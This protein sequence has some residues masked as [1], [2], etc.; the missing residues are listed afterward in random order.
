VH[1]LV[2][3]TAFCKGNV[4][5]IAGASGYSNY[6]WDDGSTSQSRTVTE[7]GTYWVLNEGSCHSSVDTFIIKVFDL[8]P[9][10]IS[11]DSFTLRTATS[12]A[13]YQWLLNGAIIPGATDST[14]TV[15]ENGKYQVI[16]SNEHG[17][18][19]TSGVY[20]I[21]NVT[22]I[23]KIS[24]LAGKIQIY[25]NPAHDIIYINTP[26]AVNLYL[27]SIQGKV[28]KQVKKSN[29][30]SLQGLAEGIYFLQIYDQQDRLIKT[31]KII[32]TL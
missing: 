22:G 28:L 29:R 15:T 19:D 8:I 30:V 3:D 12:Y 9:P 18:I 32:K 1:Q 27:C 20:K 17:C 10:I 4:F 23:N 25:P 21:T 7:A 5:T 24:R 11:V 14:Y 2:S 16:V 31:E 6:L 26:I 13:T